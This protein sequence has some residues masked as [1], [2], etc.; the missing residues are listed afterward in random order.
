MGRGEVHTRFWWANLKE[1][2]HLEDTG[3]DGKII[4]KWILQEGVGVHGVDRYGSG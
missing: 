4:L 1:G 3:I 2:D